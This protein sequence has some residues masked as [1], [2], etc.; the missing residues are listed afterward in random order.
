M[1][2]NLRVFLAKTLE[3]D[4]ECLSDDMDFIDDLQVSSLMA[5]EVMAALEK[6]YNIKLQERDMIEMRN[7]ERI[8]A[9]LK[10]KL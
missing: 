4:V 10:D 2:E 1:K 7:V 6:Q 5:M 8:H 9:L 3:V